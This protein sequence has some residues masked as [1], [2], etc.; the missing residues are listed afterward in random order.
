[1]ANLKPDH[2]VKYQR[3]MPREPDKVLKIVRL[4]LNNYSFRQI[5]EM[6]GTSHQAPYLIYKR[7]YE[8]AMVQEKLYGRRED[9]RART[10]RDTDSVS[11]AQSDYGNL[12]FPERR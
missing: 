10:T 9:S 1:M 4:K 8:W 3:R 5:G 2:V 12:N 7:W 6:I 11:Q